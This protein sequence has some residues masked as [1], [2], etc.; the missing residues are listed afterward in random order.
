MSFQARLTLGDNSYN[1]LTVQFGISQRVGANNLPTR[2]P[3]IGLINV[4][5]ESSNQSELFEWAMMPSQTKSGSIV[6]YRR[7]SVAPLKTLNFRNAFCI[8]YEEQ[9]V[10]D[11]EV[12]MRIKMVISPHSIE[13]HSIEREQPWAGFERGGN[14]EQSSSSGNGAA[15]TSSSSQDIPSFRP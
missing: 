15:Q 5:I 9:F 3:E 4:V 11:G 13:M 2:N 7:D 12:P 10:S 8:N 14:S 6:F 1:V